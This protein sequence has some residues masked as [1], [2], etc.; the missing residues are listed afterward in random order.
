MLIGDWRPQHSGVLRN[1][2]PRLSKGRTKFFQGIA[3]ARRG[4]VKQLSTARSCAFPARKQD[5]TISLTTATGIDS[6]LP[7]GN[8]LKCTERAAIPNPR[9][10]KRV[11]VTNEQWL[12]AHLTLTAARDDPMFLSW[13]HRRRTDERS[14]LVCR[15]RDV[16]RGLLRRISSTK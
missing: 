6:Q 16:R 15:L 8:K 4:R 13:W 14:R 2:T 12:I 11:R 9:Y 1:V 10:T 5:T 3:D 7:K